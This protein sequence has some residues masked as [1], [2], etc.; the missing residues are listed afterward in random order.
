MFVAEGEAIVNAPSLQDLFYRLEASGKMM[1]IDKNV[2]PTMYKCATVSVPELEQIQRIGNI[3]RQGRV[4][5]LTAN[6]VTLEGGKYTPVPDTLY[7]DCSADGLA[8]LKPVP[9]FNGRHITLQAVRFCQQV[10]SAAFIG[11]VE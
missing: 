11:H 2:W 6:E 10:F 5:R 3:V 8:R 1:R 4:V 9:V 7:I